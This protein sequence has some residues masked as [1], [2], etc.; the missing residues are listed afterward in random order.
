MINRFLILALTIFSFTAN[1]QSEDPYLWLEEVESEKSLNWVKSQ[2]KLTSDRIVKVDGFDEMKNKFVET[3]NDKDKIVYPTPV[4]DYIYNFWKD[5]SHVRGVWRRTKRR[6][7][8]DGKSNWEI[9]LDLDKL[10]EKEGKKWVFKGANWLEPDYNVCLIT[11]SDGGTDKSEIR[12]F[13]VTKKSFVEGGFYLPP[14]K[15]SAAWISKDELIITREFGK[16]SMTASGYPR[17]AKR[18]KRG[19][20]IK[21]AVVVKKEQDDIMGMWAYS[22]FIDG[23]YKVFISKSES[24]Y[25]HETFYLN[26]NKLVQLKL[27]NDAD[28]SG[29]YKGYTLLTLNSDW[30]IDGTTYKVGSLVSVHSDELLKGNIK[31]NLVYAPDSKSS[32]DGVRRTKNQ[33]IINVLENVQNVLLS[34]DLI[35][36]EWVTSKLDTPKFGRISIIASSKN[37]TGYFYQYSNFITPPTLYYT[38]ED[39]VSVVQKRKALF[40]AEN[41]EVHQYEST[42]KDGTKIP[43]FIVHQKNIKLNGKNPTLV[44]AYGGFN[45]SSKPSYRSSTGIGWLEQGGV[46]VVANIRGGGEFGPAWHKAAIK[47][48]RQ[49]AYDDFYSVCENLIAK[50][51]TSPKHMGAFG[52]SNGGLMAGV[53]AT[54]RPDLFNAVIIGAPLL[55]MKRFNKMLA[56]ASWMGEYGNPDIPEEWAYIKKYSPYHNVK[57]KGNYPEVLF[58]TSTKDDRVHPAHARKMAARMAEQ[59]HPFYYYETLEGGHGASS[60]NEQAA[61]NEALKY[62]YL[63]MKLF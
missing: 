5:E 11:L 34:C 9:I 8:L 55:D 39:R 48:K 59:G 15:G 21:D 37:N 57:S 35:N 50:K 43:Y 42:S 54:Q 19:T 53:V 63:K 40:D 27:P 25:S 13:D 52:W 3:Y 62:S 22:S 56:G 32:I 30:E 47:E 61:F 6:N 38:D 44:Y 46:Y 28:N 7:Y 2:N 23:A 60:T 18:W 1:S 17:I 58:I 20:S 36:D 12:E 45:V 31:I 51:I 14:S 26:K 10:S 24:F 29:S 49:N 16:G 4:G 33:L 41:L